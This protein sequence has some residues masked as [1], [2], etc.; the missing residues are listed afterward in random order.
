MSTLTHALEKKT[1][2]R[3]INTMTL[4]RKCSFC[5]KKN[6]NIQRRSSGH[7]GTGSIQ[8]IVHEMLL[9]PG[10]PLDTE[11]RAFMEPR[12]GHNLG[13][14]R[15]HSDDRAAKSA[16]SL[17]AFAYTVGHDIFFAD[18]KYKPNTKNGKNLLAHELVHTIQQASN[19]PS[20]FIDSGYSDPLEQAAAKFADQVSSGE[21]VQYFQSPLMSLQ[22]CPLIQRYRVPGNLS[23]NYVIDWLHINSPYKR[24]GHAKTSCNLKYAG[25]PTKKV[26]KLKNGNVKKTVSGNNRMQVSINPMTD[27]PEWSPLPRPCLDAEKNAWKSFYDQLM[28]HEQVHKKICR[29]WQSKTQ[30]LWRTI[31]FSVEGQ[32]EADADSKVQ[33]E[34][35]SWQQKWNN[36]LQSSHDAI[37]PFSNLLFC[38]ECDKTEEIENPAEIGD[39]EQ[40]SSIEGTEEESESRIG[41]SYE[42]AI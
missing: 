16:K 33:V 23:C 5:T 1:P 8:P 38:P 37:D 40:V 9:S 32:D 10:Q 30:P 24:Q 27:M 12:F 26:S 4:Q 35:E 18:G 2:S 41:D 13:R 14:I 15:I 28:A 39:L 20:A 25:D 36:E 7:V 11:S 19:M 42:S 21:A 17:N 31:K 3:Q 34:L 6:K 22:A 29:D